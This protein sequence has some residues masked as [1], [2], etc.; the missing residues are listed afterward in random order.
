M[1]VGKY[2]KNI[3]FRRNLTGAVRIIQRCS[4]GSL[5]YFSA[6]FKGTKGGHLKKILQYGNRGGG[7]D[8]TL[9]VEDYVCISTHQRKSSDQYHIKISV[10]SIYFQV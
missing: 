3:V 5:L 10:M 4:E 1:L 9:L 7:G 8:Q 6:S 2:Y